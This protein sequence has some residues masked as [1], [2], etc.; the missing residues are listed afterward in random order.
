MAQLQR[1]SVVA[2][3][4]G[5]TVKPDATSSETTAGS[6]AN[7]TADQLPEVSAET[8]VVASSETSGAT[9]A[10]HGAENQ[11]VADVTSVQQPATKAGLV[12]GAP[13]A[14]SAQDSTGRRNARKP[15]QKGTGR[16]SRPQEQARELVNQSRW[17][18]KR[19]PAAW[20]P[21][22]VSLSQGVRQRLEERRAFD[23]ETNNEVYA[24]IHYVNAA[25][26]DAPTEPAQAAEMATA[27]L[28]EQPLDAPPAVGTT[29]RLE[30]EVSAAFRALAN[31]VRS[32]ARYGLQ[33]HLQ[34][35]LVSAFLDRLDAED[36]QSDRQA[37]QPHDLDTF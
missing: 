23:V 8:T 32:V 3:T 5:T 7:S 26:R 17:S 9:E 12:A 6:T 31:R 25:L 4:F 14:P 34:S 1:R 15:P 21:A 35:A 22:P 36:M 10:L 33:G 30:L 2:G 16:K 27:Y 28:D 20:G 11:K 37:T 29:S 18:A 24:L 13:T 19:R